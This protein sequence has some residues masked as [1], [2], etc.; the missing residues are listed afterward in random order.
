MAERS[1]LINVL[2]K[3]MGVEGTSDPAPIDHEACKRRKM[4]NSES[5]NMDAY[6]IESF[7]LNAVIESE[8]SEEQ[9]SSESGGKCLSS[10]NANQIR[11]AIKLRNV[12]IGKQLLIQPVLVAEEPVNDLAIIPVIED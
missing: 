12:D 10:D 5:E 3:A 1:H 4:S 11:A 7:G 2:K 6:C 8:D 9:K